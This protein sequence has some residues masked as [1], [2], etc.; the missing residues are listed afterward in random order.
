MTHS[1]SFAPERTSLLHTL[2]NCS[3]PFAPQVCFNEA[4]K[5]NS[6]PDPAGYVY[7]IMCSFPALSVQSKDS[8]Q[9]LI[10]ARSLLSTQPK[11]GLVLFVSSTTTVE[12]QFQQ[13][14][15]GWNIK[16]LVLEEMFVPP[17]AYQYHDGMG[18]HSWAL[19]YQKLVAWTLVQYKKLAIIDMDIVVL[20]NIDHVFSLP[21]SAVGSDCTPH[22]N[23]EDPQRSWVSDVSC[24]YNSMALIFCQELTKCDEQ[25]HCL[26]NGGMTLVLPDPALYTQMATRV[27]NGFDHMTNTWRFPYVS[28]SPICG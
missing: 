13:M 19:T 12:N 6:F 14:L 8:R 15:N 16:I 3:L 23:S 7:A 17:E 11:H 26:V 10:A 9:C 4:Q 20:D 24:K 25:E 27:A 5:V 1:R 18:Q 22:D 2:R 28:H 21:H